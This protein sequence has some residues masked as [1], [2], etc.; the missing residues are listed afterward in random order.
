MPRMKHSDH[1]VNCKSYAS[2]HS[3][4]PTMD[5]IWR[6]SLSSRLSFSLPLEFLGKAEV[7]MFAR[8]LE[9]IVQCLQTRNNKN[10]QSPF[11]PVNVI[12]VNENIQ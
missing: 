6:S 11:D 3:V 5:W 2:E 7:I 12:G 10:D 1:T 4:D 9:N 8:I